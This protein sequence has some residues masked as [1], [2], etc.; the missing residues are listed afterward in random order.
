MKTIFLKSVNALFL[1]LTLFSSQFLS[2][3]D[4][5]GKMKLLVIINAENNLKVNLN[6]TPFIYGGLL[7]LLISNGAINDVNERKSVELQ[8]LMADF[9]DY[10][11]KHV[12]LVKENLTNKNNLLD[13]TAFN[14]RDALK[15][16]EGNSKLN[17][18]KLK[19]EGW[20]NVLLVD[21]YLGYFRGDKKGN[22]YNIAL[23]AIVT[24]YDVNKEK[25][26]G[27]VEAS[28]LK[29]DIL[30]SE[31]EIWTQKNI[32]TENYVSL[33]SGLDLNL[34]F[35]LLGKDLFNKMAIAQGMENKFPS[36]KLA[37]N[38]YK[39]TFDFKFP[40]VNGWKKFATSNDYLFVNAP[41][42]DKTIMAITSDI[43]LAIDELGQKD[44]SLEEYTALRISRLNEANFEVDAVNEV[45]K[46]DIGADWISYMISHPKGKSI[47]MHKKIDNFFI[48][49]EVV[50]LQEDYLTLFNKYKTD[51]ENIIK[52]SSL[53]SKS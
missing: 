16:F 48:S 23:S 38:K 15:Y 29:K 7:G 21:E 37:L 4:D 47:I 52:D 28:N 10:R 40:E 45:P 34:Y 11:Y 53:I 41:N 22:K 5:L 31:E 42:K 26:V 17:F 1:L 25:S 18:D 33:Y 27:K 46:L 6:N 20:K 13:I 35:R 32:L 44:L 3:Q 51:I 2:A 50:L 19:S 30:Y 9:V 14:K 8:K 39:K 36:V 49:H 12:A 24:A 43:D